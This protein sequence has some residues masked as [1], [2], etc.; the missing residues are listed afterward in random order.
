MTETTAEIDFFDPK[1]NDCPYPAYEQ[2]R[3][4]A[5]VWQD[6]ITG[7]WTLT[8]YDDIRAALL[9][10][11]RFTN[12]IGN[13]A[14]ATEKGVRPEDPEKARQ[15]LEAAAIEK[16][17]Q[18]LYEEKGWPTCPTLSGRDEPEHMQLRRLFDYASVLR[19]S[20]SSTRSSNSS[21]TACSTRSSTTAAAS[22]SRSSR[23]RCRSM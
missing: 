5:P 15:L 20:R 18:K 13:S 4:Q 12:R 21:P 9:D 22:S 16:E 6:P 19:G 8:R 2:L 17:I 10:T 11:E 1:T 3:S 7:M 23:S 14:G